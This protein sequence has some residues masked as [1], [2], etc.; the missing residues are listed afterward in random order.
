MLNGTSYWYRKGKTGIQVNSSI[1]QTLNANLN[2]FGQ[3]V[4][5]NDGR[6]YA[7]IDKCEG[8]CF[9][10]RV[11]QSEKA[12]IPAGMFKYYVITDKSN[13]HKDGYNTSL[14]R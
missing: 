6:K 4:S 1:P 13:A 14:G 11:G 7:F 9:G 2:Y 5:A 12:Y 10:D 8:Y 3:I